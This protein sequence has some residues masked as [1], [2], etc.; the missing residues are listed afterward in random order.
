M[1]TSTISRS[2]NTAATVK[3]AERIPPAAPLPTLC[4][5]FELRRAS[6][7]PNR[8]SRFCTVSLVCSSLIR[9]GTEATNDP[10]SLTIGGMIA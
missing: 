10:T 4:T 3:P 7:S 2:A 9:M 1:S 6:S 8:W 5:M